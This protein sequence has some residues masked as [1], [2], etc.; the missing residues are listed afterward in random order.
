MEDLSDV[1]NRKIWTAERLLSQ[2]QDIAE[3]A[4]VLSPNE[5]T[6]IPST[7]D[8]WSEDKVERRIEVVR[9]AVLYPIRH[10]NKQK[11]ED[12]GV[13]AERIPQNV[14]DDTELLH[15]IVALVGKIRDIDG[16]L[17]DILANE[18]LIER[19]L[20][21]A[22]D[23]IEQKLQDI[24]DSQSSLQ[25]ILELEQKIDKQFEYQL[26]KNCLGDTS[27]LEEAEEIAS[28]I[29]HISSLGVLVI[30]NLEFEKMC[31]MLGALHGGLSDLTDQY[32]ISG[33]DIGQKLHGTTLS[34]ACQIVDQLGKECA[35]KKTKLL[36]EWEIY[37]HTL[38]S[39]DKEIPEPP[40]TLQELEEQ[41][42]D[43]RA[44]CVNHLGGAGFRLLKFVRGEEEFPENI[45]IKD[46]EIALRILRPIFLRGLR[47]ED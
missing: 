22:A 47:E 35:E 11:L 18:H 16:Q 14:L 15:K 27:F 21:D 43:M 20:I 45:E 5:R 36:E 9:D 19:W 12:I 38:K 3:K 26:L 17:A 33:D 24:I 8:D 31:E 30:G 32:G 40:Y 41:V 28:H 6:E 1:I 10:K 37:A 7:V 42:N 39:L 2:V 34:E 29:N 4:K 46:V 44:R 25:E 23:E 13:N